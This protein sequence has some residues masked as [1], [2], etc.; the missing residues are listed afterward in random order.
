MA[1]KLLYTHPS[2]VAVTQAESAVARCGIDT[3]IRNEYAAGAVGELAPIDA[4]PELWVDEADWQ[5]ASA[6]MESLRQESD[7]PDW[8][9]PGCDNVNPP[10]FEFC[11]HCAR[12]RGAA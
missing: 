8:T 6:A 12:E 4:W 3:R 1:L 10:A 2:I 7:K 9:C 11:W 5:R